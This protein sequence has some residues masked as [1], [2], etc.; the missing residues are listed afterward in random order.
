M[1]T[2]VKTKRKRR[3]EIR[4]QK[5]ERK[6]FTIVIVGTLALLVLLYIAFAS[7]F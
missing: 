1:A 2:R 6:F 5:Q 4:D 3:K 7:S